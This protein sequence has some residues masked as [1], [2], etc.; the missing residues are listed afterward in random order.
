M[1]IN[2]PD[3]STCLFSW[4]GL[5][6]MVGGV[7]CFGGVGGDFSQTRWTVIRLPQLNRVWLNSPPTSPTIISK[8]VVPYELNKQVKQLGE[9]INIKRMFTHVWSSFEWSLKLKCRLLGQASRNWHASDRYGLLITVGGVGCVGGCFSQTAAKCTG[10]AKSR[11]PRNPRNPPKFTKSSV[12]IK[13]IPCSATKSTYMKRKLSKS[14]VSSHEI[15]GFYK[16]QYCL[17]N[18]HIRMHSTE[19]IRLGC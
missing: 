7:G 9:F 6:I 19:S 11:N 12:Y 2:S 8:P 5:L 15:N 3:C 17:R 18:T 10:P 4:Y 1:L 14:N 13:Q 16:I